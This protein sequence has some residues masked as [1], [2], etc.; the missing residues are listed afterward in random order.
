VARGILEADGP[1]ALTM[2][3][4]AAAMNIRAPSLYKHVPHKAALETAIITDGFEQAAALFE[5]ATE[6]ATEPMAAFVKAYRAFAGAHPHVYRLMTERRLPRA[7]LPPGL[8]AR[9]AAPLVRATGDAARARAAWAF[10]HG[11][12]ILEMNHRFPDDGVTESAWRSGIEA[13]ATTDGYSR[14]G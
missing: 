14:H 7:D 13:L 2:R 4:V 1:E 11:M 8:E 3:R 9:T 6:G 5:S 10:I 12:V